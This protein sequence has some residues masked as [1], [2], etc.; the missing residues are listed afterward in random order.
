MCKCVIVTVTCVMFW[1][2]LPIALPTLF[3]GCTTYL[4][5]LQDRLTSKTLSSIYIRDTC[6]IEHCTGTDGSGCTYSS[7]DC[8]YWSTLLNHSK[9]TCRIRGLYDRNITIDIYRNRLDGYCTLDINVIQY[10]MIKSFEYQNL[11]QSE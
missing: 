9:C 8:S 11:S 3:L 4:C 1:V 5:P 2:S 6:F 7:Y 10:S